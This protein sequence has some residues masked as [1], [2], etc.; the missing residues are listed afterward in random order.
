MAGYTAL[1]EK[2]GEEQTYLLMQ[3]VHRG[4]SEAVHAHEGTVQEMTGDGIMALFGAPIAIEDAPLRACQAAVNIQMRMAEIAEGF[5]A[6][7]GTAPYFRVGINSGA[8]IVGE[9]GDAH[10]S[11]VTAMG[12]T[13][14]LA[15]RL[16]NEAEA[17][18]IIISAATQALVDGFVDCEFLGERTIKGKSEPQKLWRLDG[19]REGVTRFDLSKGHGLSP[20][21]GRQKEL[22]ILLGLW[23]KA[24][25]GNLR[26]VCIRG[27]AGIGK[28]RLS[29]EFRN[30]IVDDKVF[31]L[32]CR[33]APDTRD[34]PFAP[35]MEIV[36]RSFRIEADTPQEEAERRLKQGLE[37]LGIAL[38]PS[39][40]YLMNLLGHTPTGIDLDQIAGEALGIYTRDAV[41]EMLRERC[42][43]TPTILVVEDLRW[44]DSATQALLTR[45]IEEEEDLA[46]FVITTA[47]TG[48]QPPWAE[49]KGSTI[50]NLGALSDAETEGLLQGRLNC[51]TLPD[52]LSQVVREKSQGNPLFAEEIL[53]YLRSSG[54]LTGEGPDLT[55]DMQQDSAALPVA[56]ENLLM[57]RFDKLDS[58]P[59]S[60]LEAAAAI[61]ARFTTELLTR[62][63]E[64]GP[65]PGTGTDRHL[66]AL[67]TQGLIQAEAG[68]RAY[69]FCQTLARDAIYDS[70][71]STRRQT[72][73]GTVAKAIEE[74]ESFAPDDAADTLAYHW[75]RSAEPGRAVKYFSIA[76]ENGLR[77][78]SLE[79][80]QNYLEQALTLIDEN[81]GC[82]DDTALADILLHI[83]RVLYFQYDFKALIE[84]VEPYLDRV[85]A[86][87]DNRRLSRFLF[88]IGYAHVFA[89]NIETG[90]EYLSRSRALGEADNDELAIAY[91]DLGTMWDRCFWGQPGKARDEAQREAA[92]RIMEVGQRHGDTW[93]ASK[94]GLANGVDFAGWGHPME[95]RTALMDLIALS[96]KTNDPRP[97][98]MGQ[99]ALAVQ[100]IFSGNYVEAIEIA[101]DALRIS[102]SPIDR[103]AAGLYKGMAM[104]ASG[105]RVDAGMELL[106]RVLVRA[107]TNWLT[108]TSPPAKMVMGVGMVM[109]GNMAAGVRAIETAARE[110]EKN[111]MVGMRTIGDQFLG[112]T[113]LQFAL[114]EETPPLSV[115]MANATFLLTTLPFAKKKTRHYLQSALDGYRALD[116]PSGAAHCHH[117]LGLLERAAKKT[118]QARA[119]FEQARDIAANVGADNIVRDAEAAL[120]NLPA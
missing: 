72:L 99:W 85:A 114:G 20:L 63:T 32:E 98:S 82:V 28:S 31:F 18:T 76:G 35:L 116:N 12:D 64:Q 94:A 96:R 106:E 75:S 16:E 34:T 120:A 53:T 89:S 86:L 8:L 105:Q 26:A 57:D 25:T 59:R 10:Q 110:A 115:L 30:N 54:A 2:L 78:Y 95:S 38:D 29:F 77:I 83:A 17:G 107:E 97:R 71:L 6:K 14:N 67:V 66:E 44:I 1:A 91:A 11:G 21:V 92:T 55:F 40:P 5:Q 58:G 9:V 15:S 88:E 119:S 112:Q 93:L 65:E 100:E 74:Q 4:L 108:M 81:P 101:D 27:E 62:A 79:E 104:V 36:R 102:L 45:V 80:A 117:E 50:L 84:L 22:D 68:G 19:I 118:D 70:M 52:G 69:T 7:H 111:G 103:A 49:A 42:R 46:L 113:Y 61:G 48:Y 13:V 73:H 39:L 23:Q 60:V 51:E 90:R 41:I 24:S 37:I 47:R 33:C 3:Q 109:Q 56:I 43:V 87:G